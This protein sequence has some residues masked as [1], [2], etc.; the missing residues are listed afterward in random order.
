MVIV[1]VAD[2][3]SVPTS[4]VAVMTSEGLQPVAV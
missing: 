1:A 4:A 2:R 3:L